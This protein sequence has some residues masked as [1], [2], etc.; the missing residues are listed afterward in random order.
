MCVH[1]PVSVCVLPILVSGIISYL[2]NEDNL[3]DK[4]PEIW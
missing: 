3:L 1:V 4:E 2:F